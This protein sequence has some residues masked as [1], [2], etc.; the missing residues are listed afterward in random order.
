MKL[1]CADFTFPLL[2]HEASLELIRLLGIEGVD[3]ALMG[4]RSHVR[5]EQIRDDVPGWIRRLDERIRGRGLE[6]ADVFLIPWT[7]FE[8]MAPNHPD[9]KE[10]ADAAEV[11]RLVLEVAVGLGAEGMTLLP[12]IDWPGESHE[13]SL[14]R[15]AGELAWR[16][17]EGRA[18]GVRVSVECH[19]G[20]LADTPA[21]TLDLIAA[22]PG[23]ELTL[24]YTHFVYQGIPVAEIEPLMRHARHFHARGAAPGRLQTALRESAIDY[25]RVVDVMRESGYDGY[26][27]LE[28]VWLPGDPP[29][30]V[31]DLTNT[32]NVSETVLLRDLVR[33][34]LA[35]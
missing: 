2:E 26:V 21:K 27:G 14:A 29:G 15:S 8:R 32:D 30:S 5:P 1:A 10:R 31:Y 28:Y 19:V 16:V 3:L 24:D 18:A 23:L 25:G 35:A 17:E 7:S 13:D 4:N 12:G 9:A 33:E 11:F 22:C 34:R 6:V 20:S